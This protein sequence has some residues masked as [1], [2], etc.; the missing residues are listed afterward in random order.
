[1]THR[2]DPR[3]ITHLPLMCLLVLAL[4]CPVSAEWKEK[5]LYSFQGGAN[6]GS[7]PAGGVVFDSKGNLCGAT[8]YGGLTACAI[9]GDCG[10]VFQL[11]PPVHKG[12][13]WNERVIYQF[14]GQGVNDGGVPSGGLIIDAAGNLYGVT[15]YGGSG[16]C[17]LLGLRAGCGTVYELSPPRQKGGAWKETILYSFPTAKQGYVPNGNLVFD[18]AGNLYGATIF[19]GGKGTT[20]DAFYQ[21]CGAVFKLSPPKTKGGKW[22]EKVL[23]GFAGIGTGKQFGDGASPNGGLALDSEGAVYGTTYIGGYDCPYSGGQGCGIGFR[24]AEATKTGGWTETVLHRFARR[25]SDGQNPSAGLTIDAKDYLYGTTLTGGPNGGG[26]TVFRLTPPSKKSGPWKESILYGFNG[27][28]GGLDVESPVIF[29]SNGNLYGTTL[30]SGGTYYGT[31]FQLKLPKQEGDTWTFNMLHG[32]QAPRTAVN[33]LPGWSSTRTEICT[34]RPR[35]VALAL[36][37][38]SMAAGP[39]LKSDLKGRRDR[40]ALTPQLS[41]SG[42]YTH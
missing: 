16:D 38:A 20:C 26:G 13:P 37:A 25:P 23:H 12:D 39:Y 30:D 2:S 24:L 3:F 8:T 19:G 33:P 15:G 9:G 6:D 31:V 7:F 28:G 42:R 22:T 29:D 34:A 10:T 17:V 4:A 27:T 36:A 35:R 18:G 40:N 5:V 11:S 1:M 32:F 41:L 14:R 21:Y